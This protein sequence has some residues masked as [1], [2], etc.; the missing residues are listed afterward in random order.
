MAYLWLFIIDFNIIGYILLSTD[1]YFEVLP[2]KP[3]PTLQG[4]LKFLKHFEVKP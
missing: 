1:A 3:T 4:V 2:S